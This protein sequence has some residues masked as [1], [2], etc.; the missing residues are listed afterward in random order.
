MNRKIVFSS[1]FINCYY[2]YKTKVVFSQERLEDGQK[3]STIR[4]RIMNEKIDL[5]IVLLQ[6]YD[7]SL[8]KIF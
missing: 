2:F 8:N 6:F 1:Y 5:I 7:L 4:E 3:N